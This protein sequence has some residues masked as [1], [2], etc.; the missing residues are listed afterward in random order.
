[1][2]IR[3]YA[4]IVFILGAQM[5]YTGCADKVRPE[6]NN[7]I[8][9]DGTLHSLSGFNAYLTYQISDGIFVYRDY[10]ITDGQYDGYS[11]VGLQYYPGATMLILV[12]LGVR[13]GE[14]FASGDYYYDFGWNDVPSDKRPAYFYMETE[15]GVWL[16]KESVEFGTMG[17]VQVNG[18]L[19]LGNTLNLNSNH[20]VLY[21]ASIVP[22][23]MNYK[24]KVTNVTK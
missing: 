15:T 5:V 18:D 6:I 14:D 24:G 13:E 1:M 10:I 23:Q 7:E 9:V 8:I 17:H 12:Q 19:S 11:H 20:Q 21:G 22:I 2:R 16:T 3:T 4:L